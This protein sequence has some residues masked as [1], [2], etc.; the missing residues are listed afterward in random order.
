MPKAS[1]RPSFPRVFREP[2]EIWVGY[3]ESEQTVGM[4]NVPNPVEKPSEI[5]SVV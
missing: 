5:F 3:V 1:A 2:F 4:Q